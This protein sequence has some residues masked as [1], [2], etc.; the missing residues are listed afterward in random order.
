MHRW[1]EGACEGEDCGFGY[2][3]RYFGRGR[4]SLPALALVEPRVE[5][6]S[7][8]PAR[9]VTGWWLLQGEDWARL[10]WGEAC[11]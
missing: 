4:D 1:L 7:S 11:P 10:D 8:S 9:E 2:R 6:G 5:P 3:Q